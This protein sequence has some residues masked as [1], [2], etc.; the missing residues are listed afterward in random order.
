MKGDI[1]IAHTSKEEFYRLEVKDVD[2]VLV[3]FKHNNKFLNDHFNYHRLRKAPDLRHQIEARI[4]FTVNEG[5]FKSMHRALALL[6]PRQL[7]S[8]FPP[9]SA[10]GL[11]KQREWSEVTCLYFANKSIAKNPEQSEFVSHWHAPSRLKIL[12]LML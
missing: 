2:N 1:I 6:E 12:P 4:Q 3:S 11:R 7:R 9:A 8:I 5:T 10:H